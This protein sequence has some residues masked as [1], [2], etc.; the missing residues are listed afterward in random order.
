MRSIRLSV[1]DLIFENSNYTKDF[2]E[3]LLDAKH[4][5]DVLDYYV[6]CIPFYDGFYIGSE[7]RTFIQELKQVVKRSNEILKENNS[8]VEFKEKKIN[9]SYKKIDENLYDRYLEIFT[10]LNSFSI[11]KFNELLTLLEIP[12]I[13]FS[14]TS[15]IEEM[16]T[17]SREFRR[18]LFRRL[19]EASE[20]Y[21]I[22]LTDQ[23]A[24]SLKNAFEKKL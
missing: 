3:V 13:D 10:Y 2:N 15:S 17:V 14:E 8:L 7:D 18:K 9:C 11:K 24:T 6:T 4:D 23:F 1:R 19:S 22:P 20:T 5:I 16:T 12:H 21:N